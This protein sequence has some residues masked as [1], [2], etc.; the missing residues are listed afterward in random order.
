MSA[1][2]SPEPV[3]ALLATF[4]LKAVLAQQFSRLV[5]RK[6]CASFCGSWVPRGCSVLYIEQRQP[7]HQ[8]VVSWQGSPPVWQ[9]LYK[10]SLQLEFFTM[11]TDLRRSRTC[12]LPFETAKLMAPSP[13]RNS[14]AGRVLGSLVRP[15]R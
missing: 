4:R 5:V 1:S 15:P 12:L 7:K 2:C 11:L 8:A 3:L 9:A 10:L 14:R 13:P 6:G